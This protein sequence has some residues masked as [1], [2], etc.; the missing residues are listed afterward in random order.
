MPDTTL[1][2]GAVNFTRKTSFF[3]I[4]PGKP[5]TGLRTEVSPLPYHHAAAA[6]SYA[7]TA[8][9]AFSPTIWPE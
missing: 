5:P 2:M 7:D 1:V 4:G 9:A 8:A 3:K 6:G